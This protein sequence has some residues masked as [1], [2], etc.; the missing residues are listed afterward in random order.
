MS[1][2]REPTAPSDL[3]LITGKV[4]KVTIKQRKEVAG[5]LIVD[6]LV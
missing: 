3:Q 4:V 1:S 6:Q 2:R 5:Q